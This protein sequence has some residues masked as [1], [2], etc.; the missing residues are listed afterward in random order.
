MYLCPII[1]IKKEL[2]M[3]VR[4]VF[5]VGLLLI[6]LFS[7]A[8]KADTGYNHLMHPVR[9]Y[10]VYKTISDV[11]IDGKSDEISWVNAEWSEYFKD[12]EGDAKPKPLYQTRFKMLWDDENLYILAELE[13]PN[14]W[15]YYMNRDQIIYHENDF[16]I[17]IDPSRD[18]HE[19]FEFEL[20]AQ[21]TLLDLYMPKP[22]RN[23]GEFQLDWN[24]EGF[25]SAIAIDGT[26]NNPT[27]VDKK[28]T[29]EVAIP[30]K[31]LTIS[32]EYL[33]PRDGQYWKV[34][35]SRVQWQTEV[36]DGRYLKLKDEKTGKYLSENNW[37]WS[38]QGVVDMHRPERWGLAQFSANSVGGPKV[39]AVEP[40]EERL[41]K[42]LWLIYYKQQD[43]IRKN[44][45]YA[46]SLQ[47]LNLEKNVKTAEGESG[48]C[49]LETDGNTF[50]AFLENSNGVKLSV[51]QEGLFMMEVSD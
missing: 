12:I 22:Y 21:N 29:V 38:P 6:S 13:E 9:N 48:V 33:T 43:F 37:V 5:G 50:T 46:N 1:Y 27:D 16:E 39:D 36:V 23:G 49:R 20:N 14:V 18:T 4:L 24:C 44:G 8:Q 40:V 2:I 32:D 51:N 41:N 45:S 17:F 26:L 3:I 15:C 42:Y 25:K 34:N 30:F 47:E 19:Y 28:W 35:F 31:S 7:F 10:V 11:V